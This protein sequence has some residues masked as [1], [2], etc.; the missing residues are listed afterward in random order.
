M[1]DGHNLRIRLI[2]EEAFSRVVDDDGGGLVDWKQCKEGLVYVFGTQLKGELPLPYDYWYEV[3]FRNF[4]SDNDGMINLESF[5]DIVIQYFEHY[6]NRI[7]SSD[8]SDTVSA[9]NVPVAMQHYGHSVVGRQQ[10]SRIVVSQDAREPRS[11]CNIPLSGSVFDDYEFFDKAGQGAFGKVMVVRHKQTRQVRACKSVAVRGQGELIKTEINFLKMFDH[12]NILKLFETYFDGTNMYLV[13]ELCEGGSLLDRLNCQYSSANT[14]HMLMPEGLVALIMQQVLSALAVCH[15]KGVIHR[16][17]KPDNVLFVNRSKESPLKLIDFGLATTLAAAVDAAKE[18]RVKTRRRMLFG[19]VSCDPGY[20]RRKI[21]PR[22]GTL[23]FFSPE[24][25]KGSYNEKT[26]VFSAGIVMYLLLTGKHPFYTPNVDD[27]NSVRRRISKKDAQFP[28]EIWA[29]ISADAKQLTRELLCRDPVVRVSAADA[30]KHRWFRDPLKPTLHNPQ[31]TAKNS[32]TSSTFEG[33]RDYRKFSRL[34]QVFLKL[35]ARELTDLQIEDLRRKFVQIDRSGD[36]FITKDE[37]IAAGAP[38]NLADAP[39]AYN[40]FIAAL[41]ERKVKYSKAQ[42][43]ECYKRLDPGKTESITGVVKLLR[44]SGFTDPNAVL[45]E[46][47]LNPD[48]RFTID[49]FTTIVNHG[50]V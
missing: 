4:D 14:Q 15:S 16:D 38:G 13:S 42:I 22:A 27:E 5:Y 10:S 36:G 18:V 23:N 17:V 7:D 3:V 28:P 32:V 25:I 30:L 37:L 39:I 41:S 34:K 11:D 43:R 6:R 45:I 12:P 31:T 33:L 40:E 9:K 19:C 2:C 49:D 35:L 1:V 44:K 20:A 48:G 8:Q 24:M 50:H 21:M 26:D 47:G 46:A 29:Q